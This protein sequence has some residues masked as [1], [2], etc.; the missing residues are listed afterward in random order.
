S[1]AGAGKAK[2]PEEAPQMSQSSDVPEMEQPAAEG[3]TPLQP[4]TAIHYVPPPP[5]SM[6]KLLIPVGIAVVVI[7]GGLIFCRGKPEE[8]E[9]EN[10]KLN[11]AAMAADDLAKNASV[12]AAREL[13]RRMTTGTA[14]ERT[15]A[16]TAIDRWRTGRLTRNMAMAM[17]L[18]AQKRAL[19][20]NVRM[21]RDRR[22]ARR[23][24]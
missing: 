1:D 10:P 17:A 21:G 8:A 11:Y 6:R 15:A 18:A 14:A 23:G 19:D 13:T 20:S 3:E 24:Y 9:A 16:S 12:P 7:A 2:K 5:K 4:F 22:M